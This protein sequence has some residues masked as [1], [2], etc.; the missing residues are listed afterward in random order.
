[1]LV[2][3]ACL[4]ALCVPLREPFALEVT[5]EPALTAPEVDA[6]MPHHGHGMNVAPEVRP[7]GAAGV[8]RASPLLFH[9]PGAWEVHID[10]IQ[11]GVLR[12]LQDAVTL[13][14]GSP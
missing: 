11:D 8:Y 6:I 1:M 4:S 9:M 5:L 2:K 3:T 14:A 12:R 7:A 10:V 13:E